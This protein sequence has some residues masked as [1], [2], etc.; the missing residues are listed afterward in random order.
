MVKSVI[1]EGTEC[2][3]CGKLKVGDK[4]YA[5]H[6]IHYHNDIVIMLCYSCH[7]LI[8]G[9]LRFRSPWETLYGKDKAFYDL[10]K[11]FIPIYESLLPRKV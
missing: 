8:H 4:R 3:L 6:H 2:V 5:R 11:A 9:R 10:A 1:P 7:M